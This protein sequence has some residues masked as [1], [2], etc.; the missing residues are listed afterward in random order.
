MKTGKSRFWI[1]ACCILEIIYGLAFMSMGVV[2]S[3]LWAPSASV[4]SAFPTSSDQGVW[5]AI[6]YTLTGF[7]GVIAGQE[8]DRV[9][10]LLH[11]VMA[12]ICIIWTPLMWEQL[13]ILVRPVS[14][15]AYSFLNEM[16]FITS[17]RHW[18]AYI[19]SI[20]VVVAGSFLY[21][22]SAALSAYQ[23]GIR[24]MNKRTNKSQSTLNRPKGH[25]QQQGLTITTTS[26]RR[27]VKGT[28][29]NASP[30]HETNI[31]HSATL[32]PASGSVNVDGPTIPMPQQQQQS[33]FPFTPHFE[34]NNCQFNSSN[35]P[36]GERDRRHLAF[37]RREENLTGNG[38]AFSPYYDDAQEAIV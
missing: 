8:K 14:S 1:I 21:L 29:R 2:G 36:P 17:Q 3:Y 33:N 25:Q 16:D 12:L 35:R 34:Q 23:Y 7:C 19:V 20:C 32:R 24:L 22:L 30:Q 31:D 6:F 28:P 13:Y 9:L 26:V 15:F 11:T 18:A 37:D 10:P 4:S 5:L 38:L 27:S